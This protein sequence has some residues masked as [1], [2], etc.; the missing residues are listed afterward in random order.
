MEFVYPIRYSDHWKMLADATRKNYYDGD[1]VVIMGVYLH[2]DISVY[3]EKYPGKKLVVYQLE[4][5]SAHN[6]WWSADIITRNL[7]AADEVW[8]YDVVN[9]EYLREN[10]GISAFY[11]PFLYSDTCCNYVRSDVKKD[12]DVLFYSYYTEYRSKFIYELST[13]YGSSIVWMAHIHHPQLDE[14]ISRSK[15]VLNIH[16]AEGLQQQEQTRIFYLLS[17]G[18]EVVSTKS[19]HNVYGDLIAEAETPKEMADIINRKLAEYDPMKD[20]YT[21]Y[22]F[23][24]LCLPDIL[25]KLDESN[26]T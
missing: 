16:H 15:I 21:K 3:R 9:I 13:H 25:K 19:K 18:K 20:A 10:C 12:I 5:I 22:R 23:K 6:A 11:R 4:P 1:A 2:E 17:N 8:D 24:Q 7:K 14:F 26:I